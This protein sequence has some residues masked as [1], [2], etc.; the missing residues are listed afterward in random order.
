MILF[1]VFLI[2]FLFFFT[3]CTKDYNNPYTL[4]FYFGKKGSGKTTELVKLALDHLHRGWIVYTNISIPGTRAFDPLKIG[5]FS[6]PPHSAVFIDEASISWDNRGFK[7]FDK[8]TL[9]WFRLQ[10]HYKVKIYLFSQTFDVDKKLRDLTDNMFLLERRFK[11]F[12][13][14]RR[15]IKKVTLTEASDDKPSRIDE[16]LKFDSF[17]WFWAG[18]RSI[19]LLPRYSGLFDSFKVPSKQNFLAVVPGASPVPP[20]RAAVWLA[21]ARSGVRAGRDMVRALGP[22]IARLRAVSEESRHVVVDMP[23]QEEIDASLNQTLD[24]F[25]KNDH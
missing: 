24:E 20:S 22:A 17:L 9:E 25:F 8:T 14:G 16:N 12:C 13:Y 4:N 11:I 7:S 5:Q 21:L 2:S 23:T 1:F 6:F 10:R 3:L 15:I 18:S 19:T